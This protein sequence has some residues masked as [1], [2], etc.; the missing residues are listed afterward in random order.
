ME[1]PTLGAP[2]A[3]LGLFLKVLLEQEFSGETL[4]PVFCRRFV[5]RVRVVPSASY[6]S[7][8]G[9]CGREAGVLPA[10]RCALL[11][12]CSGTLSLMSGSS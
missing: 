11:P 9:K 6:I 12:V 10:P 4:W 8:W 2:A 5:W 1:A 7:A 3:G